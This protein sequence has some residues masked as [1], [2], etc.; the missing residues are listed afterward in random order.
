MKQPILKRVW[1][2]RAPYAD[3]DP[4]FADQ[5]GMEARRR[6]LAL[7]DMGRPGIVAHAQVLLPSIYGQGYY[8][9]DIRSHGIWDISDDAAASEVEA[10]EASQLVELRADLNDLGVV[11]DEEQVPLQRDPYCHLNPPTRV[12][13]L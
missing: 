1:L 2:R 5:F 4:W 12:T 7:G 13:C 10:I 8:V 9:E 3:Q 6:A 11:W